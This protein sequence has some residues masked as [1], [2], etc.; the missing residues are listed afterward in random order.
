MATSDGMEQLIILGHGA[1]RVSSLAFRAEVMQTHTEIGEIV[2][3]YRARAGRGSTIGQI[4]EQKRDP[5][6]KP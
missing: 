5:R 1:V 6:Q 4:M 2:Q 3:K